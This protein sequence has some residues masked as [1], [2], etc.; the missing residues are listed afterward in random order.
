M[1]LVVRPRFACRTSPRGELV[2]AANAALCAAGRARAPAL[3][4]LRYYISLN[5]YA[6][7]DSAIIRERMIP[8]ARDDGA[9]FDGE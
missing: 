1:E 7:F 3:R 9:E 6:S 8:F 5:Y 2:L 4:G